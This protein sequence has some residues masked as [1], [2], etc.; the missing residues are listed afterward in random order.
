MALD[1]HNACATIPNPFYK[2]ECKIIKK[3][4]QNKTWIEADIPCVNDTP[5]RYNAL[6]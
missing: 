1:L 2:K 4:W 5:N 6:T 3:I